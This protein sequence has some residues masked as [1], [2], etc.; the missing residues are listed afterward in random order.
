MSPILYLH[1]GNVALMNHEIHLLL[2]ARHTL[3]NQAIESQ[4]FFLLLKWPIFAE[5]THIFIKIRVCLYVYIFVCLFGCDQVVTIPNHGAPTPLSIPLKS[6][7]QSVV[8]V[9]HF[10]I[11][12]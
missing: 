2:I 6:L 9:C 7:Q 5:K 10:T 3:Q 8:H 12:K 4:F 11:F 1:G